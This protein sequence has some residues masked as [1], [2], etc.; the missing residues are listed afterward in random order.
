[1]EKNNKKETLLSK[2]EKNSKVEG[3]LTEDEIKKKNSRKTKAMI[4]VFV[5]LLAVGI[6]GNWYWENSDISAKISSI[7][8][9]TKTFGEATFVDATTETPTQKE[10]PYFSS[11]RVDRQNARDSSL[12][13][14]QKIVNSTDEK[15]EARKVA[16]EKIAAISSYIDVEN[17]IESLVQAK[18]VNNCLSVVSNDGSRVDV[19]VEC[20]ELT[21]ELI[22]QIKEISTE[23]LGCTF[24]NVTIVKSN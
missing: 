1:M 18:G 22:L 4:S 2:T 16:A 24:E 7:G 20:A 11:A 15:D 17:K 21:D 14:L 23:Q 12:E 5:L 9:N 6:G 8:E 3:L 19:V 13:E 10:S